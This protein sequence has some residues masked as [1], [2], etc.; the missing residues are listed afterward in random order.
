MQYILTQNVD[1]EKS[2]TL[3]FEDG[4]T[5]PVNQGN[6]N[7]EKIIDLVTQND[8][9][10]EDEVRYL[11]TPVAIVGNELEELSE[12]I[13]YTD[14]TIFWDGDTIDNA[15]T[16]HLAR[17]I[18]EGGKRRSYIALVNFMEKL[19]T[20]PSEASRN[21]FYEF[22]DHYGITIHPDGDV[23]L[24][25]GLTGD[26]TSIHSGPGIRNGLTVNGHIKNEIGDVISLSR[27]RIDSDIKVGCSFGLH[28]G[29]YEYAS[30]FAQ[31][32]LLTVKVNP[33]DVVSVPE[34]Y[35]YQK[36]RVSRYEV[37]AKAEHKIEQTTLFDDDEDDYDDDDYYDED[38]YDDD[39]A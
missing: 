24:Y 20:N 1:K 32:V 31:G 15:L 2:I 38:E 29:T 10:D 23:I 35:E 9:V 30:S 34:D 33:R 16:R 36:V 18:Q 27:S 14:G 25:K 4:S 5:V 21:S 28:A 12:R 39:N 22:V 3:V 17:I 8:E 19:F 11:T 37:L 6:P 13:S 7:L 26:A